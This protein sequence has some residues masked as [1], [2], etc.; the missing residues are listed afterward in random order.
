MVAIRDYLQVG[1]PGVESDLTDHRAV[2]PPLYAGPKFLYE[3]FIICYFLI[4]ENPS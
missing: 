2:L 1:Q 3:F 4:I